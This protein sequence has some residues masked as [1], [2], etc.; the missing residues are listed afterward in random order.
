MT[1]LL[2]VQHQGHLQSLW[3]RLEVE[4]CPWADRHYP[5]KSGQEEKAG[6]QLC[7]QCGT[8]VP[9]LPS[10]ISQPW[11]L[12]AC[13]FPGQLLKT[14]RFNMQEQWRLAS[15]NLILPIASHCLT[16]PWFP[17]LD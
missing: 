2:P 14:Q 13:P 12:Q 11:L 17:K 9:V 7:A 1:P 5:P 15:S 8:L 3:M 6:G 10:T 4:G 16:Q